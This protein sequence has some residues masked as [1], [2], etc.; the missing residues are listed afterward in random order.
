MTVTSFKRCLPVSTQSLDPPVSTQSLDPPV[1][2][3]SLDPPVSTQSLDP[4][5][6]TQSL[7]PP[8]LAPGSWCYSPW[9]TSAYTAWITGATRPWIQCL[10]LDPPSAYSP[11]SPVP[12]RSLDHQSYSPWIHSACTVLDPGHH[13][14]PWIHRCLHT[15]LDP[16]AYTVP[17]ST[18]VYTVPGSTSVYT[19]PGS[20]SAY[21]VPGSTSVYTVPG[22]KA[23]VLFLKAAMKTGIAVDPS[24][25]FNQHSGQMKTTAPGPQMTAQSS[26]DFTSSPTVH[27][28]APPTLEDILPLTPQE[29]MPSY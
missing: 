9:I 5:V 11:G 21:T 19:V 27:L 16:G 24:F 1:S 3:Q 6:S 14:S 13:H 25:L 18:S 20:T 4:P 23:E 2:T 15:A 12:T 29:T 17:G 8:D 22:S 7:D 10:Q 26:S 28:D